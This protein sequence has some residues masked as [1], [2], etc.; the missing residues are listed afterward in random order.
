SELGQKR[1][2]TETHRKIAALW[3]ESFARNA[4][5]SIRS[6]VDA[7][8]VDEDVIHMRIFSNRPY[9]AA[10]RAAFAERVATTLQRKV[11]VQLVEIPTL[12]QGTSHA[13]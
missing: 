9:S 10:E 2:E 6:Y 7:F 3:D 12:Q 13:R 4:D 8:S 11:D 1:I 5:D